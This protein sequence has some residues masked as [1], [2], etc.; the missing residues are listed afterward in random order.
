VVA[1]A[2]QVGLISPVD[3][4]WSRGVFEVVTRE[5]EQAFQVT[6]VRRPGWCRP[7]TQDSLPPV[8]NAIDEGGFEWAV[9]RSDLRLLR[10]RRRGDS[11]VINGK[12]F[13]EQASR[14]VAPGSPEEKGTAGDSSEKPVAGVDGAPATVQPVDAEEWAARF[15]ARSSAAQEAFRRRKPV[16]G[17]SREELELLVAYRRASGEPFDLKRIGEREEI[18]TKQDTWL[19]CQP[20]CGQQ[21]FVLGT[22]TFENDILTVVETGVVTR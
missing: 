1:Y 6:L 20:D 18:G 5:T 12:L 3:C 22:V 11:Y 15:S 13:G 21:R 17:M 7:G 14:G 8:G 16:P 2:E 19:Y 4:E 10:E 9:R